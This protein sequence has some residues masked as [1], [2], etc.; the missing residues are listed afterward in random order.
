DRLSPGGRIG[1]DAGTQIEAPRRF[2]NLHDVSVEGD[3]LVRRR[4]CE[5]RIAV[6]FGDL[7]LAPTARLL[8]A[9]EDQC[10]GNPD[11]GIDGIAALAIGLANA[12]GRV[13][14]RLRWAV[15]L[16]IG[17]TGR[18]YSPEPSPLRRARQRKTCR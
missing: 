4:T 16:R 13:L 18:M 2:E 14:G 10:A 12:L 15:S 3:D 7:R 5:P 9:F 11:R 8:A 6:G 1:L 17:R